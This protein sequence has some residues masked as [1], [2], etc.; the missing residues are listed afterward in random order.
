M[1]T[2]TQAIQVR[3]R[4]RRRFRTVEEKR[5]IVE[6]ALEPGASVARVA[7]A[8]GVNAN[9]LFGWRRL[10]LEGRLEAKNRETPGLLAVRVV[11]GVR[12]AA[13]RSNART[14]CGTIEIELAKGTMRI[15][16]V[17]DPETLRA[18]LEYLT[19]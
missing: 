12:D 11:P 4:E 2:S 6:A 17:V 16:G 13:R 9:Q 15:A 5:R 1:D 18:V 19:R 7:R 10:Y 3:G 14:A 8:Y